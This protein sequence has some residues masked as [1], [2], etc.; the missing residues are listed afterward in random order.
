MWFRGSY[1][2]HRMERI[3]MKWAA[4]AI[5]TVTPK[6]SLL[7]RRSVELSPS[8]GT[9][10]SDLGGSSS[11]DGVVPQAR[12]LVPDGVSYRG[13]R[14]RPLKFKVVSSTISA[15]CSS[16]SRASVVNVLW[17]HEYFKCV[18]K[19]SYACK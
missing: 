13:T 7:H 14:K 16:S 12:S 1:A 8:I 4:Q 15:C 9:S 3:H 11:T 17:Y 5:P 19:T 10:T 18:S 2:T 6:S